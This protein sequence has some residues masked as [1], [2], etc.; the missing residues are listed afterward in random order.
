MKRY[1]PVW[2]VTQTILLILLFIWTIRTNR[3]AT[4]FLLLMALLLFLSGL[5]SSL[6]HHDN[7]LIQDTWGETMVAVSGFLSFLI[8]LTAPIWLG[9]VQR[10]GLAM[11]LTTMFAIVLGAVAF[12][13]TVLKFGWPRSRTLVVKHLDRS[14]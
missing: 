8:V 4:Y 12:D 3:E 10:P 5:T 14:G 7:A 1:L 13:L 9:I 6:R 2:I 11:G